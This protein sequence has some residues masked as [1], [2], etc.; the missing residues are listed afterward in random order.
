MKPSAPVT[1]TVRPVVDVPELAAEVV[2]RGACP[3]SV[4][5]HGPYASASMRKRTDS[6]GLGSLGSAA[7][8]ADVSDRRQRLRRPRR[9]AHRA[10]VREDGRDGR[11]LRR[12]RRLRRRRDSP[13]RP[14]AS[15]FSR[16]WREREP[17]GSSRP[18]RP[19]SRL[20]LPSSACRSFSSRC[21]PPTGSRRLLTGDGSAIAR[22]ACADALQW[23]VPAAVAH[24]FIGLAAS[25]FAALDDYGTPA[26][27][28]AAGS[29]A[30]LAL[31]RHSRPTPTASSPCREGMAVS[32]PWR[33]L[34]PL[35]V[36][37]WRAHR[38]SMPA[39]AARPAG[40]PLRIAWRCFSL[41]QRF[42]SSLQL[43]TSSASRS[44]VASARE[45]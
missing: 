41:R 39:S 9:G 31:H 40:E 15:P 33:S 6:P 26:L 43:H 44:R 16:R 3:E 7:L 36:L 29:A 5:R 27:G 13:R 20:R 18:R 30:G 24:L 37:A 32:A 14:F 1:R 21:S 42:R 25:T 34:I 19:A 4:V 12:V 11:V 45:R 17:P 28:Y 8:T 22:E 23:I 2:E 35:I 10:R 38:T